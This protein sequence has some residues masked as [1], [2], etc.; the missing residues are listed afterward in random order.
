MSIAHFGANE[1]PPLHAEATKP[2]PEATKPRPDVT[3]Q[4]DHFGVCTCDPW[5]TVI[6]IVLRQPPACYGACLS[7]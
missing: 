2:L 5:C 6:L 7:V 1:P 3:T 4:P